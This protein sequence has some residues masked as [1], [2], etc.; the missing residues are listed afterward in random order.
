M[1]K[2]F[3]TF[4]VAALAI[5]SANAELLVK[6]SFDYDPGNI[7]TVGSWVT[8]GSVGSYDINIVEENLTYPVYQDEAIG[9]AV[10]LDMSMGKN[11]VQNIFALTADKVPASVA[12]SALVKVNE[13]QTTSKYGAVLVLV[14][15]NSYYGTI[16]DGITSSEGCGLYIKGGS[17]D[18]KFAFGVSIK[19]SMNGIA[20]SDISWSDEEIELGETTLVVLTYEKQGDDYVAS[21]YINQTEES[22]QPAAVSASSAELQSTLVDI[23]GIALCQR[24]A[25]TSKNPE[26]VVDEL[27]VATEWS[28][29]FS[30][31]QGTVTMPIVNVSVNPLDFDEVYGGFPYSRSIIV[32]GSDLTSDITLKTE[33]EGRLVLSTDKISKEEAMSENGFELIVSLVPDEYGYVYDKITLQSDNAADRVVNVQWRA[34]PFE[35]GETSASIGLQ[36]SCSEGSASAIE[37]VAANSETGDTAHYLATIQSDN[38]TVDIEIMLPD[39]YDTMYSRQEEMP[40]A[41][42]AVDSE[43][44][45]ARFSEGKVLTFS[46]N[47]TTQKHTIVF[48]N[49]GVPDVTTATELRIKAGVVSAVNEVEIGD[50]EAEYYSIDGVRTNNPGKGLY[51][52]KHNGKIRKVLF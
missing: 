11:S 13:L 21:L 44:G 9:N 14:G 33:T 31:D 40:I 42:K 37:F 45:A 24:S 6:E 47:G 30:D 15:S 32:K 35:G 2:K 26:V 29:L 20:S 3:T 5:G 22:A 41:V 12:Y 25:A 50:A 52:V 10:C 8:N 23:R 1:V 18:G 38:D 49:A 34:L 43:V 27:R 36:C 46:N 28:D 4:A 39:G 19:G 7:S 51:I 16:G 17:V 48:G